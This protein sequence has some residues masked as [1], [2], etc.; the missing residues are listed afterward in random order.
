MALLPALKKINSLVA[1]WLVF[2]DQFLVQ[3]V[4][5]TILANRLKGDPLW[6][7]IIAPP[8]SGKTEVLSIVR[9]LDD[10]HPIADLTPNTFFS[11][12]KSSEGEDFSLLPKLKDKVIIH[13]DFT[14]VLSMPQ[15]K[16]AAILGQLREIYDGDWSR[17][18][19]NKKQMVFK[20]KVGFLSGCTPAIDL[21]H[22]ANAILGERFVYLRHDLDT[23][24]LREESALRSL[25][26]D[27]QHGDLQEVAQDAVCDFMVGLPTH[28]PRL[29]A[30]IEETLVR[31]ADAVAWGRCPV[32]RDGYSRSILQMPRPEGPGRVVKQLATIARG[33]AALSRH[34]EV[35]W[36][37]LDLV[38]RVAKDTIPPIRQ[39][40]LKA[41]AKA[42]EAEVKAIAQEILLPYSTVREHV[43]DLRVVG[44]VEDA[45]NCYKL[46]DRG[47][48][49]LACLTGKFNLLKK[50]GRK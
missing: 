25:K 18:F 1:K 24:A 31:L 29:P 21:H 49:V 12:Y 5:A 19:G 32:P 6:V 4:L 3:M 43:E 9:K 34:K 42:K 16:R 13:K 35:Q 10:I 40:I 27:T 20:G 15:E 47:R 11:G 26:T 36:P 45:A 2:D 39:Q 28:D 17:C 41:F 46:S 14:S 38:A 50:K 37:D 48:Q 44:L 22:R 8:S 30:D 7:M 23:D 33:S